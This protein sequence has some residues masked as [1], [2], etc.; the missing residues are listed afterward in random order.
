MS[1]IDHDDIPPY[2][3]FPLWAKI[4]VPILAVLLTIGPVVLVIYLR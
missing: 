4:A 1:Y 3:T 2:R